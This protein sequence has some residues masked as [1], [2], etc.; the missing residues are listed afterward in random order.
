MAAIG[1]PSASP[2]GRG[3]HSLHDGAG[4]TGYG[5]PHVLYQGTTLVGATKENTS[6]FLAPEV[7]AFPLGADVFRNLFGRPA[8]LPR[9][10]NPG[11][12]MMNFY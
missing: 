11:T 3:E 12:K 5:K 7:F 6:G 10:E 4:F 9:T 2:K 8:P 1:M